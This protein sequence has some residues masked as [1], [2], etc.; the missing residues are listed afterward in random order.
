MHGDKSELVVRRQL[1]LTIDLL[2]RID[3]RG[4]GCTQLKE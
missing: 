4:P 2:V 1:D 3:R